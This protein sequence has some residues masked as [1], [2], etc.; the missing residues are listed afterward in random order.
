MRKDLK[1]LLACLAVFLLP[2]CGVHVPE[3]S[4]LVFRYSEGI[5][6]LHQPTY[7]DLY[8]A[9]HPAEP[10]ILLEDRVKAYEGVRKSGR[11]TFSPDGIEIIRLGILGNGAYF[12][13][14][15]SMTSGDILKFKTILK[16]GYLSINFIETP[17]NAILYVFGE[18]LGTVV[19]FKPG[20]APGP[21][22][23]ILESVDLLWTWS[24]LPKGSPSDWCLK[25]VLPIPESAVFKKL[26]L[27]E[28]PMEEEPPAAR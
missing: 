10:V 3:E 16:P 13:V 18:P 21:E 19:R 5:W 22:R 2:G 15:E 20:K 24:R 26:Q 6:N 25:S 17:R 8:L 4:K 9:C 14:H 23:S 28:T 11:V 1:W 27:R 12:Q 7:Q